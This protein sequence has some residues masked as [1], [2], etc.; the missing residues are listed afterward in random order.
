M[1]NIDLSDWN[2]SLNKGIYSNRR[3]FLSKSALGIGGLSLIDLFHSNGSAQVH[4][5]AKAK[6][7]I[8]VFLQGGPTHLDTF[9]Y[10]PE[11]NKRDGEKI[12][13]SVVLGSPFEWEQMTDQ[14]W[15]PEIF[16]QLKTVADKIC[17]INSMVTDAPDHNLATIQMHTGSL[18]FV[19]PSIGSWVTYGLGSENRNLP[20]FVSLRTGGSANPRAFQ[21]SFLPGEFQGTPINT[22]INSVAEMI[23]NIKA[24]NSSSTQRGQIDLLSKLN[25][26]T[27]KENNIFDSKMDSRIESFEL[28]YNMQVAATEAFDVTKETDSMQE[29][30]GKTAQ[31]KQFLTARRLVEKDVRFVQIYHGSWDHHSDIK[32]TTA[33]KAAEIDQPLTA[34]VT[35][36]DQRGLLEETLI[37]VSGE[38]GRTMKRD[39]VARGNYG[40]SHWAKGFSSLMIGGGVKGGIRYGATD[41]LGQH[42]QENK[43]HIHDLHATTLHL[44]GLDHTKLVY[45]FGGRDFRLTDV[46]GEVAKE[47]VA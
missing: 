22:Q 43:M 9:D 40:R 37:V 41:E 31:G 29:L 16:P 11:V 21:S 7:V 39:N 2:C 6:R 23:S 35:D 12:G 26:I 30:Y 38:F 45:R 18:R 14:I 46:F 32:G 4:H 8:H 42:A 15:L 44:L 36:L 47:I 25:V 19:R 13:N 1:K 5:P 24:K 3:E 27:Q 28:A 34:L 17:V 20:A 10:K 33:R